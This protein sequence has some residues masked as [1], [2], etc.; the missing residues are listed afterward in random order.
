MIDLAT[1]FRRSLALG[2]GLL[3]LALLTAGCDAFTDKDLGDSNPQPPTIAQYIQEVRVLSSLEAAVDEAGLAG[4]LENEGPFTVFAPVD[5][6]FS[7][8]LDPSLNQQVIQKVVQDHA[9]SGA[10]LSSELSDGQTVPTLSGD[11]LTIGTAGGVTVNRATVTNADAQASNGVVHVVDNLLIDAVDRATLTP[12]FTIFARLV[13]E[14]G[15]ADT[16]KTGGRTIFAP[17]NEALLTALDDDDSGSIE[18]DEIPS[19]AGDLLQYHVLD[20]V[21]LAGD[22]PESETS[23]PTLEG[24]SVTLVRDGDAVTVA[25][26]GENASVT[27]PNVEVDNG[28]IH[29]IDAVL[30][31]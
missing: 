5:D 25:P 15:L 17:T 24:S 11:S 18:G 8:A 20:S 4:T 6:A 21:F 2:T 26:N 28:V 7:P 30:T 29:G 19:S 23:I 22:V 31:P 3:A 27:I 12:R 1:R 14:A 13:K 16:L 10:V 9:V